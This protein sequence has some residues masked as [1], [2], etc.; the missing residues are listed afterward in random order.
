MLDTRLILVTGISGS[1]KST[2]TRSLA[3]QLRL[4]GVRCRW[5]HEEIRRHPI[6]D[7]EFTLGPLET[8]ADY[9]RNI[10]EMYRRWKVMLGRILRSKSVYIMEGVLTDNI[11]RYFYEG[12]YPP[13]KIMEYYDGLFSLLAPANPVLVQLHRP[14]IRAA[15]ES[16][17]PIRGDWWKKLILSGI[18]NKRYMSNRGLSGDA[19]VY[20]MWED[21]QALSDVCIRRYNGPNITVDTTEGKW[22]QYTMKIT[23]YLGLKYFPPVVLPVVRPEQYCG[24]YSVV[25]DGETNTIEVCHDGSRLFVKSWWPLMPLETLGRDRFEFISFPIRLTFHKDAAGRVCSLDATGTY[26]WEIVGTRMQRVETDE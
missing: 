5:L 14:D 24:K 13:E 16:I 8:E 25:V 18:N 10:Q 9:Q 2:T 11:I 19:G 3:H 26:D 17:Y 20:S 21:Y 12:D 15:L 7:G 1:G 23:T 6:R 22:E 4:N